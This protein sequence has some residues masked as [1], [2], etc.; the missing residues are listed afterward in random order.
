MNFI[1]ISLREENAAYSRPPKMRGTPVDPHDRHAITVAGTLCIVTAFRFF[2]GGG[3]ALALF[4]ALEEK[5][6]VGNFREA[7]G[8][9]LG[10][11]RPGCVG[12]IDFM[13][14]GGAEACSHYQR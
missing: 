9:R 11:G 7:A 12:F 14:N 8:L 2:A 4:C 1:E 6:S 5:S 10:R 13:P 3:V